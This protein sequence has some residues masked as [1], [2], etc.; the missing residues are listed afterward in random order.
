M[1]I[2]TDAESECGK[3]NTGC[4]EADYI[5]KLES[6]IDDCTG[7]ILGYVMDL[8]YNAGAREVNYMPVFMKKNRPGWLITVIC[9]EEN[10]KTL[11]NIIF[12]ETTTI[13]I[14]RQKMERTILKRE[15]SEIATPLGNAVV[16]VCDSGDSKVFYPEYE[17]AAAIAKKNNVPLKE[18]YD[19]IKREINSGGQCG[20][21]EKD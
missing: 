20:K 21:K 4:E 17:S 15:I 3:A 18:V 1:I 14:R 2:E 16:K 11:E 12:S 13:G 7:E 9:K 19:I 6:N 8:L 5:Y 10:I